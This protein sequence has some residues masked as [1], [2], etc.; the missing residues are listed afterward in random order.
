MDYNDIKSRIERTLISLNGRFD[1]EI[2]EHTHFEF[3][4]LNGQQRVSIT[5]GTEDEQKVINPILIVLHNLAS[6]KDNIKNALKTKG[7]DP[8][9]AEDEIN[10]SLHL[11]VLVDI[12][13]QEKHGSPLKKSRSHKHP[14]IKEAKQSL[15]M[16]R[17]IRDEEGNVTGSEFG[18]VMVINATIRDDKG[19]RLFGLD[20]LVETCYSKWRGIIKTYNL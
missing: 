9:L 2:D 13:N 5:F 7:H 6:L 19:N 12:V 11:Q 17:A 14:V 1:E 10:N 18:P 16:G 3:Y 8:Q 15:R 4:E 20:E